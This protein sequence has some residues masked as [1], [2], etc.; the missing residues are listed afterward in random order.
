MGIGSQEQRLHSSHLR[1]GY[2]CL[3]SFIRLHVQFV[4]F[5]NEWSSMFVSFWL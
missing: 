3:F 1:M 2:K 4:L 5:T